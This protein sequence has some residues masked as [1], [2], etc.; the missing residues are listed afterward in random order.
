M[1]KRFF[2]F[3]CFITLILSP[4][5][6]CNA[7]FWGGFLQGVNQGLQNIA[8][9]QQIQ[10]QQEEQRRQREAVRE[11]ER[12]EN[13]VHEETNTESNGFEWIETRKGITNRVYG[14]KDK[15]GRELI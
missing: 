12:R 2:K 1:E 14:A 4:S 13:E 8:R 9:Q 11:R 6:N 3:I 10:R 5:V 15:N 7:Q